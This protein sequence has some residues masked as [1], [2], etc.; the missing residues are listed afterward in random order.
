MNKK[1][2]EQVG[3]DIKKF[4][5]EQETIKP[6]YPHVLIRLTKADTVNFFAV[7]AKCLKVCKNKKVSNKIQQEFGFDVL[8]AYIHGLDVKKIMGMYFDVRFP[9]EKG[10]G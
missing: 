8:M 10:K 7:V 1:N 6:K 3:A 5:D 9:K 2:L 4:L